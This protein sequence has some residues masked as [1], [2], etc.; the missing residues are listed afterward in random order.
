M[1]IKLIGGYVDWKDGEVVDF[2]EVK[3]K[4]LIGLGRAKKFRKPRKPYRT[5]IVKPE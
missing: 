3:A 5:K 2:D 1:K 4:E